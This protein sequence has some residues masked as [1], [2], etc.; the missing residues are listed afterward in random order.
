MPVTFATDL[1]DL[2]DFGYVPQVPL[3]AL[4]KN[5]GYKQAKYDQTASQ[6]QR[7]ANTLMVDA[8]GQDVAVRDNLIN[9]INDQLNKFASA[10]LADPSV[11][12]QISGFIG[13]VSKA[14]E[15]LASQARHDA[16]TQMLKQKK[17]AESKGKVWIDEGL[18]DAQNYYNSGKFDPDKRFRSTG[19]EAPDLEGSLEVIAKN[20]P[21]FEKW[22]TNGAYDDHY[23]E[24]SLDT[25]YKKY[26]QAFTSDP[27]LSRYYDYLYKKE[28]VGDQADAFFNNHAKF[29]NQMVPNLPA[30]QQAAAL[31]HLNQLQAVAQSPA[32]KAAARSYLRDL[33]YKN[34]AFEAASTKHYVSQIDHKANEFAKLEQEHQNK[35]SEKEYEAWLNSGAQVDDQGN[36]IINATENRDSLVPEKYTIK[37]ANGSAKEITMDPN[38]AAYYKYSSAKDDAAFVHDDKNQ[39]A[40]VDLTK[41]SF[42]GIGPETQKSLGA[43]W[44]QINDPTFLNK[45]LEKISSTQNGVTTTSKNLAYD[46]VN[47]K[48]AI[49][50]K[51]GRIVYGLKKGDGAGMEYREIPDENAF[52][53]ALY[54]SPEYKQSDKKILA[55]SKVHGNI[56][57]NNSVVQP[58]NQTPTISYKTKAELEAAYKARLGNPTTLTAPQQQWLDSMA[59]NYN[60]Q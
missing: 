45:A 55:A 50:I 20:T 14:P 19:F 60:L 39:V 51:N 35:L 22:Q 2:K 57:K 32:G 5:M 31:S 41:R 43:G 10:N 46:P 49:Y 40:K 8:L 9:Q 12:N 7:Q 29:L 18:E 16:Y 21:E 23:K 52:Y 24:K 26:Y 3:E 25:L 37:D 58:A 15:L 30:S 54:N 34:Q 42:F 36:H 47:G 48:P 1:R 33:W 38:L 56:F 53:R 17:D 4:F 11:A 44:T 59:T 28:N 13:K 27:K 6:L